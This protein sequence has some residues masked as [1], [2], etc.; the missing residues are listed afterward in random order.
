MS[1]FKI[2]K[3]NRI[4]FVQWCILNKHTIVAQLYVDAQ[5]FPELFPSLSRQERRRFYN[6][7]RNYYRDIYLKTDHWKEL[8]HKKLQSQNKCERCDNPNNLDVH[9]LRYKHLYDVLEEDLMVLCRKCHSD[10]HDVEKIY[11]LYLESIGVWCNGSLIVSKTIG[12]G[13]IPA[14]PANASVTQLVRVS[15][16]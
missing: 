4:P 13:S 3:K 7:K 11:N 14:A 2:S 5:H 9:H 12:A 16:F 10:E 8:K 15:D 6:D 1:Q